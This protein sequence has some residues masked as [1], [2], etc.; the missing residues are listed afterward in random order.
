MPRPYPTHM[1]PQNLQ[2]LYDFT[3]KTVI[4]TGGTGALGGAIALAFAGLGANVAVLS[5]TGALSDEMAEAA[6][7]ISGHL[8]AF[9]A[10]VLDKVTLLQA[11]QTIG[12]RFGQAEILINAAGGHRADASTNP[13]SFFDLPEEGLRYV[14]DL[15]WLGTVLPTQVFGRGMAEQKHGV[16]L[17][18]SSMSAIRALSRHISYSSAKAAIN[19]FTQWLA[20]YMASEYAPEIRVNAIAPG[21][22]VTNINRSM[23]TNPQT[24]EPS[25]RG[26]AVLA[27]TPMRRFGHPDDLA[28][29]ALWLASPAASFVT[30]IVVPVDGGFSAFSGV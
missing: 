8:V 6:K 29:A 2:Q 7:T 14:S 4:V 10:N 26:A 23:L 11:Q 1:N 28:G 12:E 17:N 25:A 13:L 18:I 5:R 3:G 24:G 22:F 9:S 21:F 27:H 16:I 15:N 30:G 20:I 19:N